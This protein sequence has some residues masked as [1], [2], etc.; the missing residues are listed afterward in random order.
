MAKVLTKEQLEAIPGANYPNTAQARK[1]LAAL[2]IGEYFILDPK[3][4]YS[5]QRAESVKVK[6]PSGKRSI[7]SPS[8]KSAK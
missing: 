5:V 1:A 4:P 2:P 6:G 8:K 3:G 7:N